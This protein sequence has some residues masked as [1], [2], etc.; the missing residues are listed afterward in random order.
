MLL[1]IERKDRKISELNTQVIERNI[2]KQRV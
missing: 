2:K 1:E